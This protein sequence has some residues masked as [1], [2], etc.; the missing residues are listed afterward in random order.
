MFELIE[1]NNGFHSLDRIFDD[2]FPTTLKPQKTLLSNSN[3]I[4]TNIKETDTSYTYEF[5]VP[6]ISKDNMTIGLDDGIL[7]LEIKSEE[8]K[9]TYKVKEYSSTYSTRQF[10]LPKNV[11]SEAIVAKLENGILS[12]SLEKLEESSKLKKIEIN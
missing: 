9:D 6:G 11:N 4:R 12:V 10:R 3:T 2:L 1:R 8:S 5:E 7:K